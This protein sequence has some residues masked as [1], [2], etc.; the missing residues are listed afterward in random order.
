MSA[1]R[2]EFFRENGYLAIERL[3]EEDELVWMREAYDRIFE[4]RAGREV[5]DQFD[6]AGADEEGVEAKLPQIL[7]PSKYAPE[8]L[9]GRFRDAVQSIAKALLGDGAEVGGDHAILKP[10]LIGAATPWHQDEAYWDPAFDY[11]ALSAWI[12]LQEATIENGCMWFV[13]GSHR[14]E[15]MSHHSIDNDPRVHGLEVEGADTSSAVACPIPAGGATFH[16]SRTL[17]YTGPNISQ[18]PRRAYILGAGLPATPRNDGR[19]FPWN[20][21]KQTAR[22]TRARGT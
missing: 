2:V 17:H 20:E 9:N 6:L 4:A 16:L 13:P 19:R 21:E 7:S 8:L 18:G 15:V 1:E 11:A 14:L 10:A 5:G 12:P 3:V 22:E